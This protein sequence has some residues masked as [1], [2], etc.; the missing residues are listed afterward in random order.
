ML[1][2]TIFTGLTHQI[3]LHMKHKKISLLGDLKYLLKHN[4][5]IDSNTC[6]KVE[7]FNRHA[8]HA[9]RLSFL[10]PVSLQLLKITIPLDAQMYKVINLFNII[11]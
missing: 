11:K 1:E 3:R 6:S 4:K 10:H 8:L 7:F 2:F 9:Y 5:F